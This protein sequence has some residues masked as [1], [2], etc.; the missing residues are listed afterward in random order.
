VDS[1]IPEADLLDVSILVLDPGIVKKSYLL[2]GYEYINPELRKSEA[3]FISTYIMRTLQQTESFGLVRMMPRNSVSADVFVTGRIRESSGRRLELELEVLAATGRRWFKKVFK[4]KAQPW[5]YA[6]AFHSHLEPFQE[7]YDQFAAELI[8]AQ[9]RMKSE[10]LEDLRRV[11]ELRFAAQLAPGIFSDYLTVD[12]K[13]RIDLDR[14]PSRDDPM[15][16][17]VR[18]IQ[19]RDEFFLDLLAERYRG[20]Y[21]AMDKPY[22]NFRAT[23]FEV[24]L[25]LQAVRAQ[26]NLA[27]A[28]M[29]FAPPEEGLTTGGGIRRRDSAGARAAFLRRQIA[30]Q[31]R[32]LDE[33]SG[34]FVTELDPLKLELD[35]EVIRFEGTIEDQY[36]QWQELLER[37]FE[38]ETG[39]SAQSKA[40]GGDL[41]ARH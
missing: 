23:R 11:A 24:E 25:A 6:F 9:S 27:N 20:F 38:T 1:R 35:G 16:T 26:A 36:R 41:N 18:T 34:A 12:R 28:R 39:L 33:I 37:I 40:G 19:T 5:S 21:A 30:A 29:L 3:A 8:S 2:R 22:D 15:L 4:Q 13:G 14:L 17:R 31:Y 7:V 10:F 32:Y